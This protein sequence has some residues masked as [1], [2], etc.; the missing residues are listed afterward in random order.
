[1]VEGFCRCA[2]APGVKWLMINCVRLVLIVHAYYLGIQLVFNCVFNQYYMR[3][4]VMDNKLMLWVIW[5][6]MV[7]GLCSM[8][9]FPM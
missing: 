1:M 3:I 5:E 2:A 4:T 8:G 9:Y 6:R 7:L